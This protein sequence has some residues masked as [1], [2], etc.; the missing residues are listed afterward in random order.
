MLMYRAVSLKLFRSRHAIVL[1][2]S[3]PGNALPYQSLNR[4]KVANDQQ[5][6]N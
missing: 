2:S 4:E 5:N 6:V 3:G 1:W